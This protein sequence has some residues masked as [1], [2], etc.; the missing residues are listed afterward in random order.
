MIVNKKGQKN[1]LQKYKF[2]GNLIRLKTFL[3][4]EERKVLVISFI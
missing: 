3:C 4:F 1:I 2:T